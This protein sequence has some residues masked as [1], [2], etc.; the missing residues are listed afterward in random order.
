MFDTQL[1]LI[2]VEV[3]YWFLSRARRNFFKV[4]I[5]FIRMKDRQSENLLEWNQAEIWKMFNTSRV[6]LAVTV[7]QR[8]VKITYLERVLWHITLYDRYG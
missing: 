8:V 4:Q 2:W 1:L 3:L 6:H 7:E 5:I